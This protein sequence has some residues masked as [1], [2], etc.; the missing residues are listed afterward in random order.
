MKKIITIALVAMLAMVACSAFAEKDISEVRIGVSVGHLTE[1]R[2]Q[3]EIEMFRAYADEAGF[4]LLVQ[5]AEDNQ[6]TQINQCENLLNQG[7]DA[8]IIQ[9]LDAAACGP[10]VDACKESGVPVIA[11]D[12]FIMNC[13][14]DYYI[15]FD[16][17]K[18]GELQAQMVLDRAPTG[19]YIWLLGGPEDNNA[20]LLLEGQ[21]NVLQPS[22]DAG[23]INVVLQQWCN[24]WNPEVALEHTENGL[25]LVENDIQGVI[26]S[27]DGTAGGAIQA[28]EAQGLAGIVPIG[29]QDADLA[30]CQRIVE[31][32]QTGTVYK[33]LAMLNR[34][35]IQLA[36]GLAQGRTADECIDAELG[37][38]TKL[39]N[40]YKD[41][42]SFS[43]DVTLIT[44]ENIYDILIVRDEFHTVEDVYANLPQD[45]WPG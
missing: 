4:E 38:W 21:T 45:Q 8:L 13:D 5:S 1:E 17:V 36:V 43:V 31:G 35:C 29:G 15:T 2:W 7:I 14:L 25:S 37:V 34:A 12:R 33:P 42:D 23:D 6:Q 24:N 44:A 10:I 41:V 22:I 26:A 3:R 39:N 40:N 32:T 18:V 20:H 30:A 11:Y 19:N 16:T 9:S 28:L 27:N